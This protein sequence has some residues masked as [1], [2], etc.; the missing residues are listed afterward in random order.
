[1]VKNFR[2]ALYIRNRIIR[3]Y[4][5]NE[6]FKVFIFLPLLPGFAGDIY[7]NNTIKIITK[8]TYKT[9]CRN[10]GYSLLELLKRDIGESAEKYIH[11]FSMRSHGV[12][13]SIPK[14]ELIY[15]HSKFI[16]V[17]DE[18]AICGSANINDRSMLGKRDTEACVLVK[19]NSRMNAV[20][21]GKKVIVGK[22]FYEMRIQL[23]QVFVTLKKL[24]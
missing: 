15:I 22:S 21:N 16:L 18:I 9:I 13:N 3:A 14:S 5:N 12:I 20:I 23:F 2:I 10:K 17:D 4:K 24:Y 7:S 19:D 1:M 11:F 8:Y 6:N